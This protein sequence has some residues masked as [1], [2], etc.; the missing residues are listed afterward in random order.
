MQKLLGLADARRRSPSSCTTPTSRRCTPRSARATSRPRPSCSASSASCAAAR[1]SC[2]ITVARPPRAAQPP[3][4]R[5]RRARRGPR[6][7][8][9][10]A[11]AVLHAGARRR[12]HGLRHPRPRR[13]GA[14]H[15]LRQRGRACAARPTGSSRSSGTTTR[16]ATT[17]V[18]VEVEALDRS[19]LLRDVAD[20]LSE[21]HV[22][23]LSCTSQTQADRIARLAVR[24]RARRPRPP[25][26]DPRR[27][28]AGRL[29]LRRAPRAARQ[30]RL[31]PSTGL[32]TRPES[33]ESSSAERGL[34]ASMPRMP[35]DRDVIRAPKG[36]LD[37][38]PPE[39]GAL[40]ERRRR[41]SRRGPSA[42]A[43]G[44]CSR[45]SSS[46][47][48]CSQRVGE[49]HRRRAQG[50]VRLRRQGRPP[51]R[52]A[53]RGHR[54]G[55]ARVRAAP[56]A[57]AVEGLV[58]RAELPRTSG[59]RRAATASTGSSAPRCSASTIPTSTSR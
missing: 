55:R 29:G 58:P 8:H 28:Q 45:R 46:T 34:L 19:K 32:D 44:C 4:R 43:T 22:N 12:D 57:D 21:H 56:A 48:R 37:V 59:R 1:S 10:A 13:L 38:L 54:V 52:A 5:R 7:R 24:V 17:S 49:T 41:A 15:R 50:D 20:V 26:L 51:P 31:T 9:G 40:D 39:S 36:M 30:P 35:A 18:S 2:P 11:L 47:S 6:R 3:P 16:P 42:S 23:I 25:R 33:R 27:G 14:P 53:A